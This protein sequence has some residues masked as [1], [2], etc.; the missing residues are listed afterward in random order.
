MEH[1]LEQVQRVNSLGRVAAT[2]A[3]EFNNVLMGIQ[4]F[5]EVIRR[6]AGD[7]E[8]ISKAVDQI[9]NSVRRGKLATH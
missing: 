5:A 4:P 8:R 9:V 1:R 7:D 6:Q 2:V 3:H